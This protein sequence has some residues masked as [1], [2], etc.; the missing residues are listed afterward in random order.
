MAVTTYIAGDTPIV[1]DSWTLA[2][3]FLQNVQYGE[4]NYSTSD[5]V[6]ITM[7]IRY[8]NADHVVN[9]SSTLSLQ[10][11]RATGLGTATANGAQ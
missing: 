10:P 7:Q 1:L 3:C 6:N 11:N 5:V 9:G 2:G 4:N 8:D